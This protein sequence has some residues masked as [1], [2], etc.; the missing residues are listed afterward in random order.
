MVAPVA[1]PPPPLPAQA[2]VRWPLQIRVLNNFTWPNPMQRLSFEADNLETG[3][4]LCARLAAHIGYLA[5]DIFLLRSNGAALSESITLADQGL[6]AGDEVR[7]AR[8][9]GLPMGTGV[10]TGEAL[11][12]AT[13]MLAAA[14]AAATALC[15][16]ASNPVCPVRS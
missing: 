5:I 9:S 13:P 7:I 8:R 16:A 3:D 14:A 15:P 6:I 11:G 1:L 4:E 10:S 12:S 2:P